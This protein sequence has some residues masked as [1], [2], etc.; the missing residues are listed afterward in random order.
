MAFDPKPSTWIPD[1]SE[2]GTDITVPIASFPEMSAVEADATT[3][4]I[5]K[6]LFAIC[7]KLHAQWIATPSANHPNRMTISKRS[8][9]N[10]TTGITT[11]YFQFQFDTMTTAEEVAAE[12]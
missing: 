8:S 3:G 10:T 7:A 4:D 12:T 5:R 2:D 9:V 11:Q 1:W 6:V